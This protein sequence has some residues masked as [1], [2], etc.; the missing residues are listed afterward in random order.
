MPSLKIVKG[1]GEGAELTLGERVTLGRSRECDLQIKDAESSR[2]HAQV[3]LHEGRYHIKDLDSSN[4]TLVNGSP[5]GE[6]V[7]RHGDRIQIGEVIVEFDD[8]DTRLAV[9]QSPKAVEHEPKEARRNIAPAQAPPAARAP[10]N[11]RAP[12]QRGISASTVIIV[13]LTALLLAAVFLLARLGGIWFIQQAPTPSMF[14]CP[15]PERLACYRGSTPKT[16]IPEDRSSAAAT[17]MPGH[18]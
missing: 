12:A 5:V 8:D 13:I 18:V 6:H 14:P 11:A 17:P 9:V 16:S 1:P 3:T 15:R 4:G 2:V 10:V 7:L